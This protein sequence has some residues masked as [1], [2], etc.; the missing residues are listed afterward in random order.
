MA[1]PETIPVKFT[2][3][4]AEYLSVRA[5]VRQ[6]FR[7]DELVD[8]V[9]RVT[10]K[11]LARVQQILRAGTLVYNFFRYWWPGFAA[12]A[13]ELRAVLVGFPD[14][15]PTRP[16]RA[17]ECAVAL[18]ESGGPPAR[19]SFELRREDASRKRLF[20]PRSFWDAVIALGREGVPA[21]QGYSYA[22]R[23]DAYALEVAPGEIETLVREA[24]RLAPRALRAQ[25]TRLPQ[26]TRIVYICPR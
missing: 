19:H 20:A 21:Y 7:L 18:L 14:A 13:E 24:A 3:E 8:M 25:L 22:R 11:D 23:G 12:D 16:F 2:E 9:L 1:L 6:T 5:V 17:E 26:V 15:D 4:E 10:G